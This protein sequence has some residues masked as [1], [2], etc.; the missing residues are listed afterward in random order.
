M[1]R[2]SP[3]RTGT[4]ATRSGGMSRARP[5]CDLAPGDD[6]ALHH[7]PADV[8]PPWPSDPRRTGRRHDQ[9][10]RAAPARDV[11]RDRLRDESAHRRADQVDGREPERLISR[12]CQR[13][14]RRSSTA[15]RVAAYRAC[16]AS[17]TAVDVS[18]EPD[19]TVVGADHVEAAGRRVAR[20]VRRATT[21]ICTARPVTSSAG[22]SAG[23][24]NVSYAIGIPLRRHSA[25]R[26][27][28]L[29]TQIGHRLHVAD[30]RK[31]KGPA[32]SGRAQLERLR[33]RRRCGRSPP[34]GPSGPA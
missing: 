20:R 32:V 34:A 11:E 13:P 17:G 1:S 9:R 5:R 22:G 21:S 16:A 33:V 15:P 10:Q 3:R 8:E 31:E 26:R 4:R 23:S 27:T 12:Q 6:P 25:A 19:V 28:G 18:R 7:P 2:I 30:T 29:F 24:P 14:C